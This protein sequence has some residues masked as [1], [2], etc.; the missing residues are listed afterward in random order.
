MDIL[1]TVKEIFLER[2]FTHGIF[3]ENVQIEQVGK[4]DTLAERSIFNHV[5]DILKTVVLKR[6]F[7]RMKMYITVYLTI[8][9]KYN[10][11]LKLIV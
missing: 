8:I 6:K 3:Y 7:V 4:I 10:N 2:K 5:I 1:K 9:F 11:F